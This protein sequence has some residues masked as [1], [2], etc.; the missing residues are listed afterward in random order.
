MKIENMTS[1]RGNKVANQ[2]II[3]DAEHNGQIGAFFQSY[4]TVVA[5]RSG[6]Y[7]LAN[8]NK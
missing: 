7:I 5:F 3:V 2:F 8:L 4:N 6:V 1:S